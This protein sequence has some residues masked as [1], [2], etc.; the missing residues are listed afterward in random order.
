MR[1]ALAL[2]LAVGIVFPVFPIVVEAADAQARAGEPRDQSQIYIVSFKGAPPCRPATP[3]QLLN[4]FSERRSVDA[5]THHFR[6][7]LMDGALVG[8]ICVDGKRGKD[9]IVRLLEQHRRLVLLD[10]VEATDEELQKHKA[11]KHASLPQARG[12]RPTSPRSA[13]VRRPAVVTSVCRSG[14]VSCQSA[15]AGSVAPVPVS[16]PGV[17]S[18]GQASK[19]SKSGSCSRSPR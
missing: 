3:E 8:R 10:C 2:A 12:S 18:R 11:M 16:S 1:E 17:S 9:A 14:C 5:R 15:R 6:T 7:E 13:P 4:A 19:I